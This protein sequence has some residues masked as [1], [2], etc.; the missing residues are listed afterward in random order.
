MINIAI[1]DDHTIFR[2]SLAVLIGFFPHCKVIFDAANGQDFIAQLQ[3]KSLP[4]IVLMDIS[5]PVM[6]GYASTSWIKANYPTIKV[7]ALSTMDTETAIIKMIKSGAKGYVLKDADPEELKLAFDE[8]QTKGY[9]YN[10]L[11]TRKILAS[12]NQL[13]DNQNKTGVFAKLSERE[14]EFL[15]LSC[16]E[17]TYKEIADRLFVSVRT[18]E[19]Y[20]DTLC[21]KLN[22]KTRVG[23]AMY[24]IKNNLVTQS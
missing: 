15:K 12:V 7:L 9:F 19:G 4:D 24:A 22:L 11:V 16:T 21:E 14:L 17:L 23:L 2:K 1:V 3:P 20:R 13:T 10:E 18:V 8:V 5:M 6:D